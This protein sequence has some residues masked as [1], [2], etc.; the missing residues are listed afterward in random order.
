[1]E[2]RLKEMLNGMVLK[3]QLGEMAGGMEV[4]VAA[5][6][7]KLREQGDAMAAMQRA[8]A[9]MRSSM[10]L[11][12]GMAA[13]G[14][15]AEGERDGSAS[16]KAAAEAS[17]AQPLKG[18]PFEVEDV[19]AR[20]EAARGEARDAV[21]EMRGEMGAVKAELAR[22]RAAAER[23]AAEVAYVKATAAHSEACINDVELALT[24]LRAEAGEHAEAERRDGKKRKRDDACKEEEMVD[25]PSGAVPALIAVG[26]ASPSS[27][28]LLSLDSPQCALSRG[29]T[30]T[31]QLASLQR[32]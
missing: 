8:M 29:S 12:K 11:L 5:L 20:V 30:S 1:M 23:Q 22:M 26:A 16:G 7:A 25:A 14:A 2:E 24:A 18:A 15:M 27:P 9:D 10:A 4:R 28:T 17:G 21:S 19:K 6:E 3:V 31:G 13:T 32:E